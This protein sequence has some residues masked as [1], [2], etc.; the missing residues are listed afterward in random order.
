V[1]TSTGVTEDIKIKFRD[2]N[3]LSATGHVMKQPNNMIATVLSG[4]P[5]FLNDGSYGFI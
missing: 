3:P 1:T 5:L 2:V 4:M